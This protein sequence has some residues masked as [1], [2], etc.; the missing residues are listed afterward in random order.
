MDNLNN[1]KKYKPS[2]PTHILYFYVINN[3]IYGKY[4]FLPIIYS[5]DNTEPKAKL[6]LFFAL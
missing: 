6:N 5:A 1:Q 3:I 2:K 4:S